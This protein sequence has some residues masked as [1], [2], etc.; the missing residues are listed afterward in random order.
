[1]S[2]VVLRFSMSLDGYV[3]GPDGGTQPLD[4]IGG[5]QIELTQTR[6][7]ETGVATHLWFS[8]D[9]GLRVSGDAR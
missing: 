4:T 6:T 2:R 1:M 5:G 8:I 3:A 7:V 9:S